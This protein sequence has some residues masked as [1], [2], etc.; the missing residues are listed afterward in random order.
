MQLEP[1]LFIM[2][3]YGIVKLM[4]NQRGFTPIILVLSVVVVGLVIVA[5]K[6]GSNNPKILSSDLEDTK[7]PEQSNNKMI[8]NSY[9][10]EYP[11]HYYIKDKYGENFTLVN[12]KWEEYGTFDIIKI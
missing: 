4:L 11:Y 1:L 12:K 3:F 8:L 9:S 2:L 6:L 7:Q 5:Y 10:V